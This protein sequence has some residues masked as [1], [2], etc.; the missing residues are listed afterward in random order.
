MSTT[1]T[2]FHDIEERVAHIQSLF[3]TMETRCDKNMLLDEFNLLKESLRQLK[4]PLHPG[5]RMI[6]IR[7]LSSINT[8]DAFAQTCIDRATDMI[9]SS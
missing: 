6:L 7:G 5:Q 8:S 4:E 2:T 9:H 1:Q 3:K